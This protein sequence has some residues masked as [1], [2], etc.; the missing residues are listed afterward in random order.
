MKCSASSR[1]SPRRSERR[2]GDRKNVQAVVEVGTECFLFHHTAEVLI[3]RG[4]DPNIGAQSVAAAQALELFFL[5]DPQKLRLQFQWKIAD[6][7]QEQRAL[8][9]SLEPSDGL[10]H[11]AGECALFATE[12][13]ALQQ[14]IR[15][16]RAT[17]CDKAILAPGAALVNRAGD[18]FLAGPGLALYE[19]GRVDRCNHVDII[20]QNTEFWAV[21]DQI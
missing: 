21:S 17:E 18:H 12:E 3:G 20:E 1:T 7:I 14:G 13:L 16:R 10:R 6:L 5:E 19:D 4:N 8:V 9:G 2:K 11:G 15:Y